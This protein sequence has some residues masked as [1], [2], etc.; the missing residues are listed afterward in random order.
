MDADE[1]M[2]TS[3]IVGVV[4]LIVAFAWVI[5]SISMKI[6]GLIIFAIGMLIVAKFPGLYTRNSVIIG[7]IA[8]GLFLIIIGI[9][10]FILGR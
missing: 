8:F 3:V 7:G 10:L 4:I 1:L 5:S 6:L 2:Q 9:A